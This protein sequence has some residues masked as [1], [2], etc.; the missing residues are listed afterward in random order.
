MVPIPGAQR[1]LDHSTLPPS[2]RPDQATLLALAQAHGCPRAVGRVT[3][4][5]QLVEAGEELVEGH[6]QLLGR[7]LGRQA[8]EAL[9]VSKQD[10]GEMEGG[11]TREGERSRGHSQAHRQ[12]Q[13]GCGPARA[14]G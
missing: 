11:G 7:A 6:D 1:F 2:G 4:R 10:A 13:D 5:S 12:P 9:D 3:H 8:G 14:L